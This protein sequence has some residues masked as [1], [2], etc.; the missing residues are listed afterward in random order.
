MLI[1]WKL[2]KLGVTVFAATGWAGSTFGGGKYDT[3]RMNHLCLNVGKL[4]VSLS[5][6]FR[7]H[8]NIDRMS[9]DWRRLF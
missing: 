3:F 4:K 2:A 6:W 1:D 7:F 8:G 9:I 5:I